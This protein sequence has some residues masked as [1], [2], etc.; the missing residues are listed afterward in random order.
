MTRTDM[1]LD[2]LPALLP[3]TIERVWRDPALL[4]FGLA[5]SLPT[6][7]VLLC[8][9][10]GHWAACR[11]HG[12]RATP[13]YFLPAP[14]GLGTFGAFI[15]IRSPIRD[16]RQLLDVGVS[17]PIAG[18]VALLPI[19][20]CGVAWS[21]PAALADAARPGEP[22][23]LYLP[24]GSLLL[25]GL[26]RAFHGG[27][28]AGWILDPHPLLL[29]GWVG[30]FVTMLNLLPL[31]QLDGGHILHAVA[32][33]APRSR[34]AWLFA[35]LVALGFV[36]PGWWVW[37]VLVLLMG[38]RHP[39]L[40]DEATPLDRGRRRLAALAL[41]IFVAGF[42]PT[43]IRVLELGFDDLGPTRS[44]RVPREVDHQGHRA[45]VDQLDLHAGA[46]PPD[47]DSRAAATQRR[48]QGSDQRLGLAGGGGAVEGGTPAPA[49]VGEQRELRDQQ[50]GAA[51]RG[52][53]EVEA[54][55]GIVE[56]PEAED[57]LRRCLDHRGVVFA[58]DADQHQQAAADG[59][60]PLASH[61]DPR[62]RHPL[63]DEPHDR[64]PFLSEPR[65]RARATMIAGRREETRRC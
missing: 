5:F 33:R 55:R 46:E 14:V 60:D 44:A 12:L 18:F 3:E 59:P 54:S 34:V 51:G 37:S 30:L 43:P 41:A 39:R 24:G 28:P 61:L 9:E 22:I 25:A 13:P 31:A 40:A 15:R 11:R 58:V 23:L 42:M 62:A 36:W 10:L 63:Q 53:I 65:D 49:D 20:A 64:R 16:R 45:V 56:Q 48:R 6:L 17:G 32:G 4:R 2:V 1:V 50:D 8:H 7:F 19:L 47:F 29:A 35:I 57:L 52:E 26:T 21:E 38:L 27:L